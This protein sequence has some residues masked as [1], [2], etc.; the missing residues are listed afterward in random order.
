MDRGIPVD[1]TAAAE[2]FKKAA[3]FE[4]AD[5]I[6]CFGCCLERSDGADQDIDSAVSHFRRAP[7]LGHPDALFNFGRCLEYGKGVRSQPLRAAKYYRLSAEMKMQ[8]PRT[9][10][11]FV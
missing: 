2:C 10:L 3:D 11:G 5:G 4:D 7:S 8:R 9:V 1:F 6:N